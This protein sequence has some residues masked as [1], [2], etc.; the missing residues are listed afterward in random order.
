MREGCVEDPEKN[1]NIFYGRSHI[2]IQKNCNA[3]LLHRYE[4]RGVPE[5]HWNLEAQKRGQKEKHKSIAIG[6]LDL[7]S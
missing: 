6:N 3:V 1:A 7:K 4:M 5:H 2:Q